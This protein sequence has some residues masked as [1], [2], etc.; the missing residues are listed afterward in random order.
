M[1]SFVWAELLMLQHL[2]TP[3]PGQLPAYQQL[4]QASELPGSRACSLLQVASG[5]SGKGC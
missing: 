2:Q 3:L 1:T 4:F 5:R